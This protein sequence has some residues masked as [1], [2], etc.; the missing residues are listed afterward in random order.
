M[1]A[2]VDAYMRMLR[3]QD[4]GQSVIKADVV[5]ALL[6]G[7]L[8]GRSKKSIE[9]RFCNISAVLADRS[10]RT[11]IGYRPLAHVGARPRDMI[12]ELITPELG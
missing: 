1:A 7:P 5:R 3:N 10:M 2:A 6:D 8:S 11:V 12:N 9:F 4:A